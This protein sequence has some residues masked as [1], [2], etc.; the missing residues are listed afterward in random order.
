MS[1]FCEHRGYGGK[2]APNFM[3]NNSQ[4]DTKNSAPFF[5]HQKSVINLRENT[6]VIEDLYDM[7]FLMFL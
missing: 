5:P 2:C 3:P 7:L 6:K 1:T 4:S